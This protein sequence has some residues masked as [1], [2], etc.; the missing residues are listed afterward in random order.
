MKQL[1]AELPKL[2]A[3]VDFL[4]VKNLSA[5][6]VLHECDSVQERWPKMPMPEKRQIVESLIEKIEIG[7]GKLHIT[8]SNLPTSIEQCKNQQRLGPG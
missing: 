5:R 8:Y 3:D 6:D 7:D 2:E 4:K 1:S